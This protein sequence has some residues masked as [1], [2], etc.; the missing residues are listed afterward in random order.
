[1]KNKLIAILIILLV[2]VVTACGGQKS[3]SNS[4]NENGSIEKENKSTGSNEAVETIVIKLGHVT[5]TTHPYHMAAEHYAALVEERTGG[6]I[7]FEI[8]PARQLGGDLDMLE[9][10]QNGSLD[11]GFITAAVFSGSTQVMQGLQLP[12]L[13]DSYDTF[14]KA[15]QTETVQKMLDSLESLN[16]KGLGINE[17]GMRHLGNNI[18]AIETPEDLSGLK[19]RVVESP[20]ML[21]IFN[22]LGTSPTPM[23]YGE[24]YSGLQMGVIDGHE[25]NLP[26][27]VDENFHEVTDYITLSNHFPFP[28]INIMNL[29]K[30]NSLTEE[31]QQILVEAGKETS[32]WIVQQLVEVD[33]K[34]VEKLKEMGKDIRELENVELFIEKVRPVYD[35]YAK[36]DPLI[37][38]FIQMVEEI[39]N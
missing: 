37:E 18:R 2:V 32:L 36:K 27:Y 24:I 26:A 21:D 7:K 34:S 17:S 10:V 30:F 16:L 33:N 28:N 4:Q 13:I 23:P 3:T 6:E 20:L 8:Y 12:F 9:M 11:A 15:L 5:Q 39:K 1:M 19:I 38:E 25:A 22:T 29:N 31:Q 14:D 35:N